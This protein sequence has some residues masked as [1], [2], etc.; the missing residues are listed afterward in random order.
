MH[1]YQRVD[2]VWADAFTAEFPEYRNDFQWDR[3]ELLPAFISYDVARDQLEL[4][5]PGLNPVVVHPP[6]TFGDHWSDVLE[7]TD[8]VLAKNYFQSIEH[9]A[10]AIGSITLRVGG[11]D[12]LIV[13]NPKLSPYEI[14]L[15]NPKQSLMESI[16]YEIFDDLRIGNFMKVTL[17][18]SWQNS[19]SLHPFFSGFVGK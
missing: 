17:Q 8:V 3:C 12:N 6:E 4:I 11:K 15:E 10:D 9:L 1:R 19:A 7:K 16:R 14:I 2:S 18:G 5:N 13:I